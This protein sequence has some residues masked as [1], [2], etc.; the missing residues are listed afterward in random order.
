MSR[1]RSSRTT[2]VSA[3]DWSLETFQQ[4][5]RSLHPSA[6]AQPQGPELERQANWCYMKSLFTAAE[7]PPSGPT[8]SRHSRHSAGDDVGE[9]PAGRGDREHVAEEHTDSDGSSQFRQ[10]DEFWDVRA[11][12]CDSESD[13]G[14]H[15]DAGI[16]ERVGDRYE[17]LR[18]EVQRCAQTSSDG[19]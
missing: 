7:Q 1:V 2:D 3:I 4:R 9:E 19:D 11:S 12:A 16:A 10:D 5:S 13:D 18:A 14:T 6:T 8:S 15:S 17:Q